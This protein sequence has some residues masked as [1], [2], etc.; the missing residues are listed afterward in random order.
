MK[1]QNIVTANDIDL[2]RFLTIK[3]IKVIAVTAPDGAKINESVVFKS[4][5]PFINCISKINSKLL[6]NAK[7]L[8][9]A[10]PI[11]NFPKYS[12][13]LQK[14]TGKLWIYERHEPN[15]PL[16]C[17][18]EYFKFKTS[19]TGITYILGAGDESC[20]VNKVGK[21][22]TAID[23]PLKHLRSF[24]RIF[25]MPLINCEIKLTLTWSKSCVL[26]DMTAA[27]NPP[28]GL[29]FQIKDTKLCVAGV[30]LSL[31]DDSNKLLEQLIKV[32]I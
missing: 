20:D 11:Y 12:Q 27:N 21:N 31:Q 2:P 18:S 26:A 23:V 29:E 24:G 14:K 30:T 1:Y 17:N 25:H 3:W 28:T 22:E 15:N 13:K 6:E 7:D 32:K 9:V 19:I 16:S 5:D 4:N 8:D 10:M